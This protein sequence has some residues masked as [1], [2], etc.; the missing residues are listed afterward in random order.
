MDPVVQQPGYTE[1]LVPEQY[2]RLAQIGIYS[3]IGCILIDFCLACYAEQW[4]T[5]DELHSDS[6]ATYIRFV[7]T[8]R[9]RNPNAYIIL[10]ATDMANGEIGS[11]VERVVEQLKKDGDRNVAFVPVEH[12][13]FTGCD[14]H[15]STADDN[16]IRD[17]LVRVINAK[18]EIWQGQ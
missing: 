5:R 17:A 12:L 3:H 18:P 16:L 7:H 11:E 4:K 14:Y 8:L 2:A 15:P 1:A 13:S 9:A 10:W 6:E